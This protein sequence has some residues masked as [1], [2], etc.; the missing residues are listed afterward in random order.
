MQIAG[1]LRAVVT[2]KSEIQKQKLQKMN[3]SA[4]VQEYKIQ[5]YKIQVSIK[6]WQYEY[7][8]KV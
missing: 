1:T 6:I 4:E 3:G 2:Q 7:K 8:N 5:E